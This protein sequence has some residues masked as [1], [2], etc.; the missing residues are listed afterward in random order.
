MKV[1]T[2]SEMRAMDQTAIV[3]YGIAEEVLMENAG[4]A[5]FRVLTTKTGLNGKRTAVVCGGGNNGGDGLVV[6]RHVAS[7]GADVIVLLLS[8]P[9]RTSGAARRNYEMVCN[10]GIAVQRVSTAEELAEAI[11]TADIV[12]DAMLGTGIE[13][14]VEGLYAEAIALINGGNARVL[15]VDIPSGINGD[16]GQVMGTAVQADWTATFGLPKAGNLL[17]PGAMYG[18]ELYVSH[19]SFPPALYASEDLHIEINVPKPLPP[20][21]TDGNKSTFGQALFVAGAASYYGAPYLASMS[22]LKAGGGYSRLA[23]PTSV[24]PVIAAEGHEIVFVPQQET[25]SGSIALENLAALLKLTERMDFVVVG[26]GLSLDEETQRLVREIVRGAEKPLL[27]D[28]DGLSAV[29]VEPDCVRDRTAPTVIT[30]HLGE[31]SR[32]TGQSVA[33]LED[34]R[35]KAVRALSNDYRATVVMKGAHTL[36]CQP[37]G[38]I[39]INLTGN[40]GMATAGSGDVLTGAIAAMFG[41]GLPFDDAVRNGVFV[42][43]L[44]GDLATEDI[45]ADGMSAVD[46]LLHVPAAVRMLREHA[47]GPALQRYFGPSVI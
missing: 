16:T 34:D 33:E 12:V 10:L 8:D 45:G 23:A 3:S 20:R 39:A 22:F 26:P 35:V 36:V 2:V 30:P 25:A 44:A 17:M 43:G 27:I 7:S 46:V 32:L 15:C 14:T 28:G 1:S 9:E 47:T 37:D 21:D 5:A 13:R 38:R 31:M 6:A 41:L 29:M 4:L 40:S 18:G 11:G 24:V 42:H 19:I